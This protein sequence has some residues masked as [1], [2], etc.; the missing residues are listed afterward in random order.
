MQ[1]IAEVCSVFIMNI[2]NV[3]FK[4]TNNFLTFLIYLFQTTE[5]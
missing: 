1:A 5:Q 3:K 2:P 4:R